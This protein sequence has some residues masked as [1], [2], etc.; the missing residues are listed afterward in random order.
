MRDLNYYDHLSDEF[1]EWLKKNPE[2]IDQ[3]STEDILTNIRYWEGNLGSLR[4]HLMEEIEDDKN[5]HLMRCSYEMILK[6]YDEMPSSLPTWQQ[7]MKERGVSDTINTV[8]IT[9]I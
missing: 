9:G 8:N 3:R 1:I 5:S 2:R 7:P 4:R 6:K